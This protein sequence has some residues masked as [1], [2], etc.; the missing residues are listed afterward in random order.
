AL[1]GRLLTTKNFVVRLSFLVLWMQ[2]RLLLQ[3]PIW[4]KQKDI[5]QISKS[6]T[7]RLFWNFGRLKLTAYLI[8]I[9][10]LQ[11]KSTNWFEG[12]GILIEWK[13]SPLRFQNQSLIPK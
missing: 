8:T 11:P 12:K 5:I 4:Q 7:T 3:L 6:T 10:F 1:S 2:F 13:L 9:S